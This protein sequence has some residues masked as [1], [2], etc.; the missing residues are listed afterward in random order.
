MGIF[1]LFLDDVA[2]TDGPLWGVVSSV[3]SITAVIA[4]L[5]TTVVLVPV[6]SKARVSFG[7]IVTLECVVLLALY[8]VSSVLVFSIGSS[9][10]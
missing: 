4:I 9:A 3:H 6:I 2:Y 10:H 8:A 1:V 5:M 7:R